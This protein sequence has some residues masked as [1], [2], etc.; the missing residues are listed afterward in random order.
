M[1]FEIASRLDAGGC[2]F[3]GGLHVLVITD[4]VRNGASITDDVSLE[5]PLVTS[6]VCKEL[7]IGAGWHAI[8]A[9]MK[10]L[11]EHWTYLHEI[12]CT[13]KFL[14]L[15]QLV[16]LVSRVVYRSNPPK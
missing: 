9:G 1:Q 8:D 16:A 12:H 11:I 13:V 5:A 7:L 2:C 4:D 14:T 10:T 15:Q 3:F 6:D